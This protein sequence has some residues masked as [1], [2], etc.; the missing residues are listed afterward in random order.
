MR[1]HSVVSRGMRKALFIFF[2]GMGV[3]T[4]GHVSEN[5]KQLSLHERQCMKVFFE[6]MI[7][8]DQGAH[9]LFFHNKPV[10]LTGP[11]LKHCD[12]RF[13]DRLAL[14]GWRAFRRH[15]HLFPHPNF[16]FSEELVESG[17]DFKVL[18]IYLINRSRLQRCLAEHRPLFQSTLGE[19]FHAETFMAQL[20]A[21]ESLPQLLNRSEV[22]LGVVLG[23]GEESAKAFAHHTPKIGAPR[24][25]ESYCRIAL[26]KPK[27][28]KIQP[29]VFMGN[30][31]SSEVQA[32]ASCYEQELEEF[33]QHYPKKDFLETIL[34][35]LCEQE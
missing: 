7:A 31:K 3:S 26:T 9:V 32:L 18:N 27:R 1:V 2:L 25:N 11:A 6:A 13:Q 21:G 24:I 30:P 17:K 12:R 4:F 34:I 14:K 29:V 23:Y 10:C 35:K 20:E 8:E 22:L 33:V 5:L 15:E 28:T 19:S 16:I